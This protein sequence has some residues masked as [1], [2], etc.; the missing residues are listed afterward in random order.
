MAT[1]QPEPAT[2]QYVG[3]GKAMYL[4]PLG[5]LY[6]REPMAWHVRVAEAPAVTSQ[7]ALRHKAGDH[8]LLLWS[9]QE[10]QWHPWSNNHL[11]RFGGYSIELP[12]YQAAQA[13]DPPP[14]TQPNASGTPT[15]AADTRPAAPAGAPPPHLPTPQHAEG[16]PSPTHPPPPTTQQQ[17]QAQTDPYD[18][19][20][21]S[22]PSE[23]PTDQV[24]LMQRGTP[25]YRTPTPTEA[26]LAM[27]E[28]RRCLLKVLDLVPPGEAQA[29]AQQAL[30]ALQPEE[31]TQQPSSSSRHPT[32]RGSP[33][34][35]DA[36]STAA[37]LLNLLVDLTKAV[38]ATGAPSSVQETSRDLNEVTKLLKEGTRQM[39]SR[40][41]ARNWGAVHRG[42][43][44]ADQAEAAME[45]CLQN[46]QGR[47]HLPE[48]LVEDLSTVAQLCEAASAAHVEAWGT[49]NEDEENLR[50]AAAY[51]SPQDKRRRHEADVI[52]HGGGPSTQPDHDTADQ[53]PERPLKAL[54]KLRRLAA[55]LHGQLH[56][57][58]QQAIG[59][60]T[61][62]STQFWGIPVVLV[63]DEN[64]EDE[65]DTVGAH[66]QDEGPP[67]ELPGQPELP[68]R[69][70]L[71]HRPAQPQPAVLP[72][73]PGLPHRPE[74][75]QPAFHTIFY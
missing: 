33:P 51:C 65:T 32:T 29:F 41:K 27:A 14:D 18:S 8:Y 72:E 64:T 5:R 19:S 42:E 23:D 6:R 57:W 4:R 62:W 74:P 58:A 66:S 40:T 25:H 12:Q 70:G 22:W 60:L 35:P 48:N 55:F 2:H 15:P 52:A 61:Q 45:A 31:S 13:V 7:G 37:H 59:E 3:M 34:P 75:V 69:P 20:E 21:Q 10:W 16:S 44:F 67:R 63:D 30:V 17:Q 39:H 71:P 36:H 11:A 49:H 46:L 56:E 28:A 43:D 24:E 9:R 1:T 68:A 73:R 47:Q 53:Q 50:R 54:A 38:E 26:C